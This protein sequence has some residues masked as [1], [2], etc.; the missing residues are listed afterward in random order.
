MKSIG[1]EGMFNTND[2]DYDSLGK[3]PKG[4]DKKQVKIQEDTLENL[5]SVS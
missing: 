5:E 3:S 1:T 2:V 4:K